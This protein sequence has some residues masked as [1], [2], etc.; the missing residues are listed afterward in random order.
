MSA[1]EKGHA[2][3]LRRLRNDVQEERLSFDAAGFD[4]NLIHESLDCVDKEIH[5]A[6]EGEITS[7]YATKTALA[8]EKRMIEQRFFDTCRDDSKEA[9]RILNGLCQLTRNHVERLS[10]YA[11]RKGI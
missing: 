10:D 9:Q 5:C 8:I 3:Q 11:K 2:A 1:E 7:V 4:T 6:Q